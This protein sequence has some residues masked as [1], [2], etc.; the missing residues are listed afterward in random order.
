MIA[1]LATESSKRFSAD[2]SRRITFRD[3]GFKLLII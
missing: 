2:T 3:V 1:I